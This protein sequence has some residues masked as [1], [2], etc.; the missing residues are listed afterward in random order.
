MHR[1]LVTLLVFTTVCA[2]SAPSRS[3]LETSSRNNAGQVSIMERGGSGIEL[4]YTLPSSHEMLIDDAGSYAQEGIYITSNGT[5][6]PSVTRWVVVPPRDHVTIS[7]SQQQGR[8]FDQDGYSFES[9]ETVSIESDQLQLDPPAAMIGTPQVMRGIRMVPVTIFPLQIDVDND[10]LFE[11]SEIVVELEFSAGDAQNISTRDIPI[12]SRFAKILENMTINPPSDQF[13]GRDPIFPSNLPS[14]LILYSSELTGN[15]PAIDQINQFANWKRRLGYRVQVAAE[16]DA[17]APNNVDRVKDAIRTAYNASPAIE[18]AVIIGTPDDSVMVDDELVP[19]D[20]YFQSFPY[21][22]VDFEGDSTETILSDNFLVTFDGDDDLLPDVALGRILASNLDEL[23]GAIQRTILYEREPYIDAGTEWYTH[24]LLTSEPYNPTFPVSLDLLSWEEN[25]LAEMGYDQIDLLYDFEDSIRFVEEIKATLEQGVSLAL[26]DGNLIGAYATA[27]Y[28]IEPAETGRMNPFAVGIITWYGMGILDKFF[29]NVSEEQIQGPVAVLGMYLDESLGYSEWI[30]PVLGTTTAAMHSGQLYDPGHLWMLSQMSLASTWYDLSFI[31]GNDSVTVYQKV[32]QS[33]AGLT[34]LGDPSVNVFTAAPIELHVEHPESYSVGDN[35]IVFTVTDGEDPVAD[36]TVIIGYGGDE[37]YIQ[38]TDAN[39]VANFIL[40]DIEN[41]MPLGLEEGELQITVYKHNAIPYLQNVPIENQD[42]PNLFVSGFIIDDDNRLI[43]GD[44]L[45]FRITVDNIGGAD[46][47]GV[48]AQFSVDNEFVT[49]D[50][51]RIDIDDIVAGDDVNSGDNLTISLAENVPGGTPV[52][53]Q[54]ELQSGEETWLSTLEFLTSGVNLWTHSGMIS[55]DDEFVPG[56]AAAFN[57]TIQNIGDVGVGAV[58]ATLVSLEERIEVT[59][60]LRRYRPL[61]RGES[62]EPNQPF[63]LRIDENFVQGEANFELQ[64]VSEDGFEQTVQISK[65]VF[66]ED[67]NLPFEADDYGYICFDSGDE[68][69][70]TAPVYFWRE[71]NTQIPEGYEFAGTKLDP[72]Y[73]LIDDWDSTRVVELPFAFSYYGQQFEDIVVSYNGWISM[74]TDGNNYNSS[75]NRPIPGFGAPDAQICAMW[76][77]LVNMD[78]RYRG[79]FTH[80]IEEE[81]IFVIEWSNVQLLKSGIDRVDLSF[82]IL[83]FDPDIYQT[84]TGDGEIV[85]QYK[86][87][88][89]IPGQRTG[90]M[91]LYP[92]IGMRNLDGSG[93]IQYS[94]WNEYP[95]NAHPIENEFAIKFTTTDVYD[96][97]A[98]RGRVVSLAEPDSVIAGAVVFSS[99]FP[100]DT[101]DENGYFSFEDIRA[102]QHTVTISALGYNSSAVS[103]NVAAGETTELEPIQMTHPELSIRY[104]TAVPFDSLSLQAGVELTAKLKIE[105]SGNGPL[106]YEAQIINYDGTLPTYEQVGVYNLSEILNL[107]PEIPSNNAMSV[108]YVDAESL[109]YVWSHEEIIGFNK[110]GNIVRRFA[111][112][113]VNGEPHYIYGLTWDGEYFWGSMLQSDPTV[114]YILKFDRDGNVSAQYNTPYT[115]VLQPS[116]TYSPERNTLFTGDKATSIYEIDMEGNILNDIPFNV[117]GR[118]NEQRGMVWNSYDPTD[119]NLYLLDWF[120]VEDTTKVR[121]IRMSVDTGFWEVIV[122]ELGSAP[123]NTNEFLQYY[124]GFA[125]T[126]DPNSESNIISIIDDLVTLNPEA[127]D[128][129]NFALLNFD[130]GP[131]TSFLVNG[132]LQNR[133]GVVQPDEM[134]EIE[135]AID[136]TGWDDGV[137]QFGI[138]VTHNAMGG[139]LLVPVTLTINAFAGIND[140]AT[141][142]PQQFDLT[143]IYPNPF[144]SIARIQFSVDVATETSL[145]V[146][147]LA[148]R[149]IATLYNGVP[150]AG[151]YQVTWNATDMP[152]GVYFVRLQSANQFKSAKVAVVK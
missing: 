126:H 10:Q 38:M 23:T 14:M 145:T 54:V 118:R 25:R 138:R 55:V 3:L 36:A 98:V 127:F 51:E 109:Y 39:G 15:N 119:K 21:E 101:T 121:L 123:G 64:L 56:G 47:T 88:Q 6:V 144:N 122:E 102:S 96:T 61:G 11:N 146:Y 82:Q 136:V 79:V 128:T 2:Y 68:N 44:P 85:I 57:P 73:D 45:R 131:N 152:S 105:N 49:I 19:T 50:P 27:G 70:N 135:M 9:D 139:E 12:T 13:P 35:S 93:G 28:N 18:Y 149:K 72:T 65:H 78:G 8:W 5:K 4:S 97:G 40:A 106:E 110:E 30:V 80:Y 59:Q 130:V 75:Y 77:D 89:M 137:Q 83:L 34:V 26:A 129:E 48:T 31:N 112:P 92:T 67:A 62:A 17:D 140:D 53:V 86:E 142:I 125:I 60:N 107:N 32:Q 81:G 42:G 113:E 24:G 115:A 46:A 100:A 133:I 120:E 33:V 29:K 1:L 143:A 104:N 103:F 76:Q 69:W 95:A 124:G 84:T 71:L 7:V 20:F 41:G 111:A 22:V 94:Y 91:P 116:I 87:F 108:V 151:S 90:P 16:P 132:N 52:T 134:A 58:T 148:G 66:S 147:D 114:G 141:A 74:G 99:R 150:D 63:R 37:K 117:P 43:S